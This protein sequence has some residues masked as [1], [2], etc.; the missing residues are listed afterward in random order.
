[1]VICLAENLGSVIE[2]VNRFEV[3]DI[4]VTV[5]ISCFKLFIHRYLTNTY[6]PHTVVDYFLQQKTVLIFVSIYRL[7]KYYSK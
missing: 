3:L 6:V 5:V 4:T 2:E 1:M 7:E